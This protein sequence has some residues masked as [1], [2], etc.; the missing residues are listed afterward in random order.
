MMVF[1][2]TLSG[3]RWRISSMM[4]SLFAGIQ[5]TS[6]G[7]SVP[8][9]RTR[10]TERHDRCPDQHHDQI[11]DILDLFVPCYGFRPCNIH[12]TPPV[13]DGYSLPATCNCFS[14]STLFL[15][16]VRPMALSYVTNALA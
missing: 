1:A 8:R 4:P 14:I 6:S 7:T 2:S 15:R 12:K 16:K 11:N 5:R 13:A 10:E 9:P 3:G